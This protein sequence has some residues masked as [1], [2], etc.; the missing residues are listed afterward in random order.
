MRQVLKISLSI[1][2]AFYMNCREKCCD[3]YKGDWD[4]FHDELRGLF[5][6]IRE[7]AVGDTTLYRRLIQLEKWGKTDSNPLASLADLTKSILVE[8]VKTSRD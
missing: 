7:D 2:R 3:L 8:K 5:R 4:D 1:A 6:A